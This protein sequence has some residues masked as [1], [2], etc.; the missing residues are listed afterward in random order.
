VIASIALV[1]CGISA[2]GAQ[3]AGGG[4]DAGPESSLPPNPDPFDSGDDASVGVDATCD[5]DFANDPQHCGRC[6]RDCFGGTCA[7]ASCAPVTIATGLSLPRGITASGDHLYVSVTGAARIDSFLVDGGSPTTVVP[8][9]GN[10]AYLA[11]SAGDLYWTTD[12]DTAGFVSALTLAG[13]APRKVMLNQN[14]PVGIAF[15]G[16]SLFWTRQYDDE[17]VMM[18]GPTTTTTLPGNF[19]FPE[20]LASKNGLLFA[21][22]TGGE[23]FRVPP[24]GGAAVTLANKISTERPTGIAVDDD[25]MFVTFQGTGEIVHGNPLTGGAF[26]VL[27]TGQMQPTGITSDARA[28]YW[29]NE[30]GGSIMKLAK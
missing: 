23:V 11:V 30:T 5:A 22:G 9:A 14:H 13:G 17:I 15:V 7:D 1:A 3:I 19:D 18:T 12:L 21:C 6:F 8:D 25:G 20:Q 4:A 24:D 2:V 26:E 27:A 16:T 28:L 29:V 10:A